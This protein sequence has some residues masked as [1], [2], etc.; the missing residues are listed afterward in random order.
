MPL[1]GSARPS[2]DRDMRRGLTFL[3]ACA[4]LVAVAIFVGAGCYKPDVANGGYACTQ[5]RPECPAGFVCVGN[6]CVDENGPLDSGMITPPDEQDFSMPAPVV[7]M[8]MSTMPVDMAGQSSSTDMAKPVVPDMAQP[9][10]CTASGRAC[11]SDDDCCSGS[12]IPI[13]IFAGLC[14]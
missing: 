3:L 14:A 12:C 11:G 8:A 5:D 6:R 13:F 2:Y 7:D 4:A 9:P 10:Q 1:C